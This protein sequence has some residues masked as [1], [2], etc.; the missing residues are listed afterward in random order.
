MN[1]MASF[2]KK[3]LFTALFIVIAVV[4]IVAVK[5]KLITPKELVVSE[6][7]TTHPSLAASTGLLSSSKNQ[8]TSE[9][10]I[11]SSIPGAPASSA[12]TEAE[13]VEK[14]E[15][16]R[17]YISF[18]PNDVYSTYDKNTNKKSHS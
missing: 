3:A 4:T 12:M 14:W 9:A 2:N 18:L 1:Y 13:A 6:T 17:G 16:D 11:S 8:E 5:S 15:L 10:K 7:A